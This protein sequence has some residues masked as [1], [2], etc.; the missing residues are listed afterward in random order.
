MKESD[1]GLIWCTVHRPG[2]TLENH[3]IW[4]DSWSP[5]G[6]MNPGTPEYEIYTHYTLYINVKLQSDTDAQ[7]GVLLVSNLCTFLRNG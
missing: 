2:R 4:Q 6:A 5:D 7:D 3:E 1:G